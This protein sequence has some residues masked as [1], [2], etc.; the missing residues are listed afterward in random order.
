MTDMI[1][2]KGKKVL[3]F[4]L[5]QIFSQL[6]HSLKTKFCKVTF[7]NQYLYNFYKLGT[8]NCMISIHFVSQYSMQNKLSGDAPVLKHA[9]YDFM[10]GTL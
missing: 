8:N 1:F 3:L 10:Y 5:I 9:K 2:T 7:Q 4:I 6:L